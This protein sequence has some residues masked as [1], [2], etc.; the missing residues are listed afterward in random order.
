MP[1]LPLPIETRSDVIADG[2]LRDHKAR[3]YTLRESDPFAAHYEV[4]AE[5]H[6]DT[7]AYQLETALGVFREFGRLLARNDPTI[8][9]DDGARATVTA[10]L[11]TSAATVVPAG[12]R[13]GFPAADPGSVTGLAVFE[14]TQT[15]QAVAAGGYPVELRSLDVGT[16][17][18][19]LDAQTLTPVDDRASVTSMV[20]TAATSGGADA[21]TD[22]AYLDRLVEHLRLSWSR[23]VLPPDFA[24]VAAA[25]PSVHRAVA[26]DLY[27]PAQT[28]TTGRPGHVSVSVVD[29]TGRA[30]TAGA[31]TEV[32]AE[33]VRRRGV[34][35]TPHVIGPTF[36]PVAVTFSFVPMPGRDG[37][38][39]RAAAEQRVRGL[40]DPATFAG[41]DE[42]PPVWRD[43]TVVRLGDVI[44]VVEGTDGLDHTV[45]GTVRLNAAA[46]DLTIAG[47]AGLPAPDDAAQP[48]TVVGTVA[49]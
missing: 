5:A 34:N 27:D 36:T 11:T 41:G 42:R 48:S 18:N 3:G 47:P 19:G 30:L 14:L 35:V 12:T 28:P 43:L 21:E 39:V 24:V 6:A 49:S 25:Q 33:L 2:M 17:R 32:E 23:A 7:R 31:R 22:V 1:F 26:I 40:I 4:L 44:A 46:A 38:V 16:V 45:T 8:L 13:Y 37:N 9:P 20:T 15:V 10:T 29:V